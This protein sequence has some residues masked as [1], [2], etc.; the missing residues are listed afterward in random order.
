MALPPGARFGHYAILSPLGRGGMG[1]VYRARDSKLNREVAIKVL[2]T[3]IATDPARL[4]RFERE[5]Q[6]LASLNHPNIA[7]I[8]GVEQGALIMELIE[9][10][11][12]A[13]RIH[14][15]AIPRSDAFPIARQIATG[16]EAAHAKGIIHRDLKP[17][18]IKITPEG[19]VKIL[20]F[21]L[22]KVASSE[23]STDP[24]HSPT[25]T[26]SATREGDVLGTASYM[27]PEQAR[28]KVVD[29]RADI[30]AFGCTLYEMLSGKR[31]FDGDSST[32]I[33]AS[34]LRSDPDWSAL[35][36]GTPPAVLHLLR[37][38]VAKDPAQRLHDIAD[39]RIELAD[40]SSV[41]VAVPKR[42][43]ATVARLAWVIVIFA[44]FAAGVLWRDFHRPREL[45][46]S[47]ERLGG[48]T[49]AMGP[50]ISPDGQMIAFQA[51]VNNVTQV[52]VLKLASSNWTTLTHDESKG[53]V[54][55]ISW[56]RDGARLYY[57]RVLGSAGSMYSVPLLGGDERLM[58]ENTSYSQ[59]LPDGSFVVSRH[60]AQQY[61]QLYRYWP[62]G[63]RL[64]PLNASP[65]NN[66]GPTYRVAP[67]GE[68][69]AFLGTPMDKAGSVPHLYVL[70]LASGKI[71][72]LAPN[73]SIPSTLPFGLAIPSDGR[74]V[75]FTSVAGDM[76]EI[77][78]VPSDG[79]GAIRSILRLTESIGYVDID[80][81]GAIFADQWQR[82]RQILRISPKGTVESIAESP[83][84]VSTPEA[85]ATRDGSVIF[86]SSV[87]GRHRLLIAK[88]GRAAAP[89]V[90]TP[91]ESTT[92]VAAVGNDAV[93]FLI[94][95]PP[96]QT[97]A[98]ASIDTGRLMQ[99]FEATRGLDVTS[100]TC[101]V[102]GK[103]LYYTTGESVW[104]ISTS[105]GGPQRLGPGESVTMNAAQDG[106]IVRRKNPI[107]SQIVKMPLTG[108]PAVE[109]P[110]SPE[111]RVVD[112]SPLGPTAVS[113]DGKL[114]VQVSTG[115]MW[116]WPAALVD[117][118]S[119]RTQL[120]PLSYPA[121]ANG[122]TWA[123]DGSIVMVAQ[124][125][126]SSMWRFHQVN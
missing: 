11:T 41:P 72:R 104:S 44:A 83:D 92:P 34:V 67:S 53:F 29:R 88:S 114:L 115:S 52:A 85:I 58:L 25:R 125:V 109:V 124:P 17:D 68:W 81:D 40:P 123:P 110:L 73:Q 18:N 100:L 8:Y 33:L 55:D 38:C 28:G 47:G 45:Q 9:G 86:G 49:V 19:T 4:A 35:P 79:S 16:L 48:S 37:R 64:Q 117:I 118:Y 60:N 51:M 36:A 24:E 59:V 27:A 39:A 2:P 102:N 113:K 15:G 63:A 95:T 76:H 97:I 77:A 91:E 43:W 89:L 32:D 103:T 112:T 12:L 50:R 119:G 30:W 87:G 46:W 20:D 78:T 108:S 61:P 75:I 57:T 111:M 96:N 62:D 1:E 107:G 42:R 84:D 82:P 23:S 116:T 5:A 99:R 14:K 13:E 94:G 10:V 121:D 98:I 21:G 126:R 106:L 31:A 74:S 65:R 69:L 90:E 54:S 6:V 66:L 122:A 71:T 105:S 80:K 7:T 120:L 56:S 3:G 101:S 93:G 70:N 22:A 26:L